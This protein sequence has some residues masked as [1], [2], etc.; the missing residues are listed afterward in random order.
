MKQA[1]DRLRNLL[2]LCV[3][4]WTQWEDVVCNVQVS[5]QRRCTMCG[6]L[7]CTG[8]LR[9]ATLREFCDAQHA[10]QQEGER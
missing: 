4:E 9:L 10:K 6:R 3:H 2:G 1:I 7:Q 5:Q 8:F